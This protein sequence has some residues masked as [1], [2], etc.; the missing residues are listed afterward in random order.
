MIPAHEVSAAVLATLRAVHPAV[1]DLVAPTG[2]V[3]P[4]GILEYPPG[5]VNVD[6]DIDDPERDLFWH[7]RIRSVGADSSAPSTIDGAR[8]QAQRVAHRLRTALLDRAVPIAGGTWV[9]AAREHVADGGT[10]HQG[11]VVNVVHDFDL[12]VVPA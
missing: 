12:W 5:G 9:V 2:A 6:T 4:Y 1:Y 7:C 8:E 11:P 3:A 10:D